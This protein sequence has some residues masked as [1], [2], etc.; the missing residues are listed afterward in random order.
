MYLHK[1]TIKPRDTLFGLLGS[2]WE[3]IYKAPYNQEFRNKFPN[4]NC[5]MA[6]ESLFVQ[7]FGDIPD[8]EGHNA[9][10]FG[11]NYLGDDICDTPIANVFKQKGYKVYRF[12]SQKWV[13]LGEDIPCVD[14]ITSDYGL[15]DR[16]YKP[17]DIIC[18]TWH[19]PNHYVEKGYRV[20]S[21]CIR[22]H[23]QNFLKPR[24]AHSHVCERMNLVGLDPY[25]Y[26]RKTF[27]HFPE[28]TMNLPPK[29]IAFVIGSTTTPTRR[30]HPL[31]LNHFYDLVLSAGYHPIIIC[32]GDDGSYGSR[33]KYCCDFDNRD[34]L[35]K[36]LGLARD[37]DVLV[38]PDS[39]LIHVRQNTGKPMIV[40]LDQDITGLSGIIE[41]YDG[42][43]D[44]PNSV[45]ENI[46]A[47]RSCFVSLDVESALLEKLGNFFA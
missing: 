42:V 4:P 38:T 17:G 3:H 6:G 9:F 29:T 31:V 1:V 23:F 44:I 7:C 2:Y 27:V 47:N 8:S 30:L 35:M 32:N 13:P 45:C 28:E 26:S 21:P 15:L 20:L 37:V 24:E 22:T 43:T 5:I 34:N 19:H 41:K 14:V 39:G 10:I 40:L 16:T 25:L 12:T 33:N 36:C 18:A 11:N 46:F